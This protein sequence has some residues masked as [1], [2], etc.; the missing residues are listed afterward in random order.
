MVVVAAIPS[1]CCC[2]ELNSAGEERTEETAGG[3]TVDKA[4]AITRAG[5]LE[6]LLGRGFE[7][8]LEE[9]RTRPTIAA[10][11]DVVAVAEDCCW[12]EGCCWAEVAGGASSFDPTAS[13]SPQALRLDPAGRCRISPT[14]DETVPSCCCPISVLFFPRVKMLL[15]PK[16]RLNES[17][18][19]SLLRLLVALSLL[20]ET[21]INETKLDFGSPP[22]PPV[23]GPDLDPEPEPEPELDPAVPVLPA[24]PSSPAL[25]ARLSRLEPCRDRND[26]IHTTSHSA[27]VVKLSV[28]PSIRCCCN[29]R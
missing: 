11:V 6:V 18:R 2:W 10:V 9:A 25:K 28:G 27:A 14:W 29:F 20:L 15:I 23:P 3:T 24:A 12:A 17:D 8:F 22:V 7:S 21:V 16:R 13:S 26:G 1:C 4:G 19:W 5:V